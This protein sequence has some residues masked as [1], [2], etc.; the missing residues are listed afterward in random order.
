MHDG[1]MDPDMLRLWRRMGPLPGDLRL[2]DGTALALYRN[3]R[4]STD[5]DFCTPQAVVDMDFVSRL[6][7]L[8]GAKL[9]GGNGMVDA[10]LEADRRKLKITFMECGRMVP[11]PIRDP[12]IAS[13]GVMVAH[14]VDLVASR[15]EACCNR[16]ALRDYRD[17]AEALAAWP[18]WCRESVEQALPGRSQAAVRRVLASPPAEVAAGLRPEVLRSLQDSARNLDRPPP[19]MSR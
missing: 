18:S 1:F 2:Y 17:V 12:C 15:I 14:P 4:H 11:M 19:G 10:V 13:N 3:H 5:F 8:G 16:G 7:W 6:P 9:A